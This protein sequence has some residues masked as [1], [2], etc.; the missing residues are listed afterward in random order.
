M[1]VHLRMLGCRLNQS[2][3]DMMARQFAQQGHDVVDTPDDADVPNA[4]TRAA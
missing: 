1:K 3:I 4:P 2:E